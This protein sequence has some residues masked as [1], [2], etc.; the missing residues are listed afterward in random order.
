MCG[1]VFL[2]RS[3][4]NALRGLKKRQ[5]KRKW[6]KTPR[7]WNFPWLGSGDTGM[8]QPQGDLQLLAWCCPMPYV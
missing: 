7:M 5:G 8:V 1:C 4:R 2:S 3:D 6:G